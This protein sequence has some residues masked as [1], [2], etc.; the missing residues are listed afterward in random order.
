MSQT[1]VDWC[2]LCIHLRNLK[3]LHSEMAEATGLK[4]VTSRFF[5]FPE[6]GVGQTQAWMPTHVSIL[7]ILHMI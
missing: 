3:V 6:G 5:S 4:S 2:K 1:H 7:R